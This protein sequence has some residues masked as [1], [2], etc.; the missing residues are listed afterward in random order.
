M[1]S[2]SAFRSFVAIQESGVTNM[3]DRTT[4]CQLAGISKDEYMDIIKNYSEYRAK[5]MGD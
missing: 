2:E 3:F 1:A 5:Y 4:V